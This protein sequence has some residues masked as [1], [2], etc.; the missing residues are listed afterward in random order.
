[1]RSSGRLGRLLRVAFLALAALLAVSALG[2]VV[3]QDA[4]AR[5]AT[6]AEKL[7]DSL[8]FH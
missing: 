8:S 4:G 1:V 2:L 5:G 6:P 3:P 7:T